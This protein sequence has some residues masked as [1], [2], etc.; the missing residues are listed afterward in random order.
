M[1]KSPVLLRLN[2]FGLLLEGNEA[3]DGI[4]LVRHEFN[5]LLNDTN[6]I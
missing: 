3:P 6:N 2:Q 1:L 5:I 4:N